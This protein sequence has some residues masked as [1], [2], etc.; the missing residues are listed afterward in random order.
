MRS[1]KWMVHDPGQQ[2]HLVEVRL[3]NQVGFPGG[4]PRPMVWGRVSWAPLKGPKGPN[5]TEAPAPS[6]CNL[7]LRWPGARSCEQSR[8]GPWLDLEAGPMGG[9]GGGYP[10][11]S[12][13]LK[14]LLRSAAEMD[15]VVTVWELVAKIRWQTE[16][17]VTS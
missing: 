5:H 9:A 14:G 11:R 4:F 3:K 1:E 12:P 16:S 8:E 13:G 15:L 17:E 10:W 2:T 6:S 7:G